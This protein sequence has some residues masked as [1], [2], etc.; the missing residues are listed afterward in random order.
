MC[1]GP[2]GSHAVRRCLTINPVLNRSMCKNIPGHSSTSGQPKLALLQPSSP[3]SSNSGL[4][5]ALP[6]L[7]A[8]RSKMSAAKV[9]EFSLKPK[10]MHDPFV[11]SCSKRY[12]L[13]TAI[14]CLCPYLSSLQA[15]VQNQ[16]ELNKYPTESCALENCLITV[17]MWAISQQHQH[18]VFYFIFKKKKK[19]KSKQYPGRKCLHG[20]MFDFIFLPARP[21]LLSHNGSSQLICL[22][23]PQVEMFIDTS[24][25]GNSLYRDHWKCTTSKFHLMSAY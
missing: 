22:E 11:L 15:E 10:Y 19:L 18:L 5:L 8:F 12:R 24:P 20:W 4:L 6:S 3:R 21:L 7:L 13:P 23:N 1:V 25:T 16:Y 17:Q 9:I 14:S 2:W